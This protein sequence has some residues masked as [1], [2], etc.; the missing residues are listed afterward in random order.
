M[1]YGSSAPFE[2]VPYL[3]L[4]CVGFQLKRQY[5]QIEG[6]VGL[7][8]GSLG[9]NDGLRQRTDLPTK[10]VQVRLRIQGVARRFG[11]LNGQLVSARKNILHQE[12][13][14]G[15][16]AEVIALLSGFVFAPGEVVRPK[17]GLI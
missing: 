4:L 15:S 11:Q 17:G 7:L 14:V 3:P 13:A 6:F 5:A 10:R 8:G 16:K 12:A 9:N 1:R 2:A